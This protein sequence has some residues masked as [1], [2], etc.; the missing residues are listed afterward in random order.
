MKKSTLQMLAL[1]SGIFIVCLAVQL[2]KGWNGSD[3]AGHTFISVASALFTWRC[4]SLAK[5]DDMLFAR[6]SRFR[7]AVLAAFWIAVAV[8]LFVYFKITHA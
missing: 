5:R 6:S 3:F 2:Y 8:V 1:M 7:F 4:I